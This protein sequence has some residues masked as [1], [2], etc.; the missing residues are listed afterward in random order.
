LLLKSP[1]KQ[2]FVD[3]RF[4]FTCQR[5]AAVALPNNGRQDQLEDGPDGVKD[6]TNE[7]G[8]LHRSI[9]LGVQLTIRRDS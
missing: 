7:V 6:T 1:E 5:L 9:P 8:H 3:Q 4:A 2:G